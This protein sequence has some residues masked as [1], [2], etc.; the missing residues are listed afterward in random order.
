MKIV[1]TFCLFLFIKPTWCQQEKCS[2]VKTGDFYALAKDKKTIVVEINR[3]DSIQTETIVNSNTSKKYHI[4]WESECQFILD[5]IQTPADT[6]RKTVVKILKVKNNFYKIEAKMLL[7]PLVYG[8]IYR[9][10]EK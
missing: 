4:I 9:K 10:L 5:P 2:S 1:W 3:N 7:Q 6:L 8:K